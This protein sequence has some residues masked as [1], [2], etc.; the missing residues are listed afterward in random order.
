MKTYQIKLIDVSKPNNVINTQEKANSEDEAKEKVLNR[1]S[2]SSS[3]TF[4]VIQ[5]REV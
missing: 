2:R 4:E 1:Y 3:K 5:C